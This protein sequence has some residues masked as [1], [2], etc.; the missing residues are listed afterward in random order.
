MA[1]IKQMIRSVKEQLD[2]D[3]SEVEILIAS[4][5]CSGLS[6]MAI[7]ETLGV[8]DGELSELVNTNDFQSIRQIV[9]MDMAKSKQDID[10]GWDSAERMA[11]QAINEHIDNVGIKNVDEALKIASIANKAERRGSKQ[12][13]AIGGHQGGI[14]TLSLTQNFIGKIQGGRHK[15]ELPVGSI[16]VIDGESIEMKESVHVDQGNERIYEKSSGVVEDVEVI[17]GKFNDDN[18]KSLNGTYSGNNDLESLSATIRPSATELDTVL[19][20]ADAIK[21]QGNKTLEST[22]RHSVFN[23]SVRDDDLKG[24]LDAYNS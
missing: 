16:Q 22:M 8:D 4:Y 21:S 10:G 7:C 14:L 15:N 1:T 11:L 23:D 2:I 12:T 13:Q 24:V 19:N 6:Q 5:L 17:N 3:C 9:Q 20:L 18:G